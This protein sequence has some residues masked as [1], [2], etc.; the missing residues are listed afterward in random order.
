MTRYFQGT[1]LQGP[2]FAS[3]ET[4]FEGFV[5][6]LGHAPKLGIKRKDF[7]ALPESQR[8][9]KK[10]VPFFV[11]ACFK[12]SPSPRQTDLATH[13]NLLMLDIDPEKEY[14]NGKWVETGRYPA[15][16]FTQNI[17]N[18]HTALAGFNFAAHTTASSTPER[19]RMRIIVEADNISIA[20]Y[21]RAVRTVGEMLGLGKVTRESKV[22]VQAMFAPVVF[23]DDDAKFHPM[24]TKHLEGRAFTVKD[25]SD[26][27]TDEY[28]KPLRSEGV[29]DLDFLRA[30]VPEV[31]L[32]V[33]KEVLAK[34]NPDVDRFEWLKVAMALRH[35]F[36]PHEAEDAY[37]L[38]DEWSSTGEKY[39]GHEDTQKLWDSCRPTPVGRAPVTIHSL[40]KKAVAAGWDGGKVQDKSFQGLN[41][42]IESRTSFNDLI[43]N[44]I[45]RILAAPMLSEMR[46]DGL[47]HRLRSQ[48]WSRFGEKLSVGAIRKDM[49]RLQKEI[50]LLEGKDKEREIEWWAQGV[51]Y[52]STTQRFY[53]HRT[54][55]SYPTKSWDETYSGELTAEDDELGRPA[56][57]PSLY[58]LNKLKIPKVYDQC[59]DPSQP[60]KIFF[61]KNGQRFVNVYSPTYPELKPEEAQAAGELLLSHLKNLIAEPDYRNHLIDFMAYMV[62]H[63]G[64]KIRWAVFVQSAEGAGKTF[65][66]EVMK[67]VLGKRHVRTV[68]GESIKKGWN[69]WSTGSQMVVLEEVRAVGTSRHEIMNVLKPLITNDDIS[70]DQRNRDTRETENCTNYLLLSNFQNAL[71]ISP[72]NRRYF[73]LKSPLQTRA[74][75]AALG[76]DYFPRL[77]QMLKEQPGGLRSWLHDWKI[78]DGFKPHGPPPRTV[79]E[80]E[81]IEDSAND[82][83]AAVRRLLLE[84]DHPL[85]QYDIVS[86]SHLME[87][88]RL[89]DGLGR[90]SAQ[91]VGQILREEGFVNKKRVMLNGSDRPTL[92]VRQGGST[93][94]NFAEVAAERVKH[95]LKNLCMELDFSS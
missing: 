67:A 88:L 80:G 79:Y 89:E 55:E 8:N 4:D 66:A 24:L 86:P 1:T 13:C 2:V 38:F 31:T 41:E 49:E 52:I 82:L 59:Y 76:E 69:E 45:K 50:R 43:E 94:G 60:N 16:P 33:A 27:L 14:Q 92:W 68:S 47:I 20:D 26:N 40:L 18:L 11:P 63:P 77:Y 56:M 57:L 6:L 91:Q 61:T 28:N 32:A 36:S 84:A 39:A 71:P 44:G 23:L 42:W 74:A 95:N 21:P 46:R 64:Q 85:V 3:D 29:D 19:P 72:G 7:F 81:M 83:H 53:R 75:V 78:T 5:S 58:C 34:I 54:G 90:V 51:C 93:N 12:T 73:I 87:M 10:Q 70:I 65:L 17:Q 35:Q 62:Q 37:E 22:A 30:Q 15:M 48:A 9:E 25:I